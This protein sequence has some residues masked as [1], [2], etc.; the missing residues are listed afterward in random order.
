MT[1]MLICAGQHSPK[2]D[3]RAPKA[4]WR[5]HYGLGGGWHFFLSG[6]GPFTC[7]E[8]V[9]CGLWKCVLWVTECVLWVRFYVFLENVCCG[10]RIFLGYGPILIFFKVCFVSYESAL[11]ELRD[12]L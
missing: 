3:L 8:F 5:P 2:V 7:R 11:Y 10:L 9:C 6:V 12:K 4:L 1:D